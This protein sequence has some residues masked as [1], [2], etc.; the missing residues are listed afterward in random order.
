MNTF[1]F[2]SHFASGKSVLTLS[3]ISYII[4]FLE[5]MLNGLRNLV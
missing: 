1:R 5:G 4:D 2:H 3:N